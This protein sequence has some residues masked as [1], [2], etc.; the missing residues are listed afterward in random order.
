MF[1]GCLLAKYLFPEDNP[2]IYR[3]HV[4]SEQCKTFGNGKSIELPNLLGELPMIIIELLSNGFLRLKI[5]STD[6]ND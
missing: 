6:E 3:S 1:T 4:I 2:A 5:F